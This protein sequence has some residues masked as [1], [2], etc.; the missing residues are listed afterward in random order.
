MERDRTVEKDNN[1]VLE[2]EE[3]EE[4]EKYNINV[5]VVIDGRFVMQV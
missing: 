5:N 2:N 4:L 1:V 3:R